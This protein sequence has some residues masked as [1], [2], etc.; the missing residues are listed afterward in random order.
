VLVVT[1]GS[2]EGP[3][4]WRKPMS[5]GL[6]FGVTLAT[7]GWVAWKPLWTVRSPEY[8]RPAAGY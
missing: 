2:W 7:I 4:S 5:F 3:V 8:S 6:S 1:G